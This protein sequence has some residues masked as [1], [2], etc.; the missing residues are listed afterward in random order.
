MFNLEILCDEYTEWVSK[1]GFGRNIHDVRFGQ[2]L[3]SEYDLPE[4]VYYLEDA[5]EIFSRLVKYYVRT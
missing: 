5:R 4:D 3:H 1:N 2:Y